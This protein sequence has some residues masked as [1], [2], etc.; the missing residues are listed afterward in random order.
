MSRYFTNGRVLLPK[1]GG[2]WEV[3]AAPGH[4]RG[5][6]FCLHDLSF[7]FMC[8][9]IYYIRLLRL[10]PS[11]WRILPRPK[12]AKK[13]LVTLLVGHLSRSE[14]L[15]EGKVCLLPHTSIFETSH[16]SPNTANNSIHALSHAVTPS[17]NQSITGFTKN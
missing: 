9:T 14:V 10:T 15:S 12:Q 5:K 11:P 1:R 13:T 7:H 2:L 8:H 6:S 4:P 17:I 3:D 16:N